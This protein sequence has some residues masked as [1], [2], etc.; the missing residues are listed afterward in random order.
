MEVTLCVVSYIYFAADTCRLVVDVSVDR[1]APKSHCRLG[2]F[3]GQEQIH[4]LLDVL[5][6]ERAA[7]PEVH[8]VAG[9]HSNALKDVVDQAVDDLHGVR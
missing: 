7:V 3:P 8:H 9:F 2:Q 1:L 5:G 6:G 4:R